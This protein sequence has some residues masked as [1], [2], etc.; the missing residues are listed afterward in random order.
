MVHN[1]LNELMHINGEPIFTH[2]TRWE[3]AIPQYH[4]GHLQVTE[5]MAQFERL[6]PGLFLSGNYRGG[7]SVS[8]CVLQS[9]K[10]SQRIIEYIASQKTE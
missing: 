7:I 10:I 3:K 5:R 1:E 9:E 4:L 8:D 2:I 6:H